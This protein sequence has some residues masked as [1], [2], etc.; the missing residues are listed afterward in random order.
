MSK[1]TSRKVSRDQAA[2]LS[3]CAAPDLALDVCTAMHVQGSVRSDTTQCPKSLFG[4]PAGHRPVQPCQYHTDT[5]GLY[6]KSVAARSKGLARAATLNR[7]AGAKPPGQKHF[8]LPCLDVGSVCNGSLPSEELAEQVL[9]VFYLKQA[10]MPACI[11]N[12]PFALPA[13][14]GRQQQRCWLP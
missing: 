10:P 1:V 8:E 13:P 7:A 11:A 12:R 2:N 3:L 9:H 5:L 4:R 6:H 14:P